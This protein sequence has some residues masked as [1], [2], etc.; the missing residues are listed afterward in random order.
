MRAVTD[1]GPE[2]RYDPQRQPG[3]AN[4]LDILAACV[5]DSPAALA[6]LF[7]SYGELKSA[8][9]DTVVSLLRPMQARY[10]DLAAEPEAVRA[11]LRE[12]AARVRPRASATV[13]RARDAIGLGG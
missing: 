13:A 7:T 2:V 1:T 9:A 5:D 8:V 11:V 3:V 12:G 10:R 4:L 6:E